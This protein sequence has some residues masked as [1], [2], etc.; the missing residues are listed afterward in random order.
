MSEQEF[1][2]EKVQYHSSLL[3]ISPGTIWVSAKNYDRL[4]A[5]YREAKIEAFVEGAKWWEWHTKNAT[6]WT[7]DKDLARVAALTKYAVREDKSST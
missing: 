6:M 5:L 1:D 7:S 2:P 4:L 3:R